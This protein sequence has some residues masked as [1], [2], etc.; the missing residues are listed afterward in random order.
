MTY[1][2][3]DQD[4]ADRAR[5]IAKCVADSAHLGTLVGLM[6]IRDIRFVRVDDA[7]TPN[8]TRW[9]AII[10]QGQPDMAVLRQVADEMERVLN[11]QRLRDQRDSLSG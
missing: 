1:P 7:E 5:E 8:G 6:G 11:L 10:V 2:Q 9:S 4:E 3:D